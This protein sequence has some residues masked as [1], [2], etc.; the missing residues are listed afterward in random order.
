LYPQ[1]NCHNVA[2]VASLVL[3]KLAIPNRKVW[4]FAPYRYKAG[5][6]EAICLPDPNGIASGGMISWG[7]HVAVLVDD[8]LLGE[9]VYDYFIN[10]ERPLRLQEWID[11]QGLSTYQLRVEP[12]KHYLFY[13]EPHPEQVEGLFMGDFFGYEGVALE[14]EWV[15]KGLAVNQTAYDFYLEEIKNRPESHLRSEYRSL[16]GNINTFEAF[17]RDQVV[18]AEL[19]ASFL[20]RHNRILTHYQQRYDYYL[21][22]WRQQIQRWESTDA[23]T[24][25]AELFLGQ[26]QYNW[27]SLGGNAFHEEFR[28]N[29]SL[30]LN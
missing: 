13:A 4:L 5:A 17:F 30:V 6:T 20:Q 29:N 22:R 19:S 9:S 25:H 27:H 18:P 14:E 12:S 28:L 2:H 26:P 3:N 15:A 8:P 11:I 1:G 23:L 7:Y 10:T 24:S 21:A 16:V